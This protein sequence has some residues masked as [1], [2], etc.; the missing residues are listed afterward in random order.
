MR[1]ARAAQTD[2]VGMIDG[3]ATPLGSH[4]M[5][6]SHRVDHST[7]NGS[8][9]HHGSRTKN[10]ESLGTGTT[11]NVLA[12]LV[13]IGSAL[14]FAP[15]YSAHV[16]A[17]LA[18]A[19][20]MVLATIGGVTWMRQVSHWTYIMWV[21]A[22]GT[23]IFVIALMPLMIWFAWPT[24]SAQ[25]TPSIIGNCNN[26]GNNN[27]NCN[28]LNMGPPQRRLPDDVV[29]TI[30][31]SLASQKI[32]GSVEVLTDLMACPDCD[33]FARQIENMLASVNG[34]TVI[35]VRNG[36][37][38]SGFRG[39]ALG[40]KDK[41]SIPESAKAIVA[42]FRAAGLTLEIIQRA[43]EKGSDSIFIISQPIT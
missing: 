42:A 1:L 2:Y 12:L 8:V 5:T 43:P 37:T 34:W 18:F 24:A 9:C 13:A 38:F 39:V 35:P 32:G 27:I 25:T 21:R 29:R 31:S 10:E 7:R 23:M 22:A 15:Q 20:A 41:S 16:V 17:C 6:T 14:M 40:V 28:T 30:S 19:S 33:N 36:I 4:S 11:W 3:A 26:V